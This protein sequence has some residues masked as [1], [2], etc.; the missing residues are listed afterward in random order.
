MSIENFYFHCGTEWSDPY[1]DS[2][3]NDRCPVC[4]A[5][6]EPYKSKGFSDPEF[7]HHP[8]S[9]ELAFDFASAMINATKHLVDKVG[10]IRGLD[11]EL[12]VGHRIN[13]ALLAKSKASHA[14]S[15]GDQSNALQSVMV[16]GEELKA[17]LEILTDDLRGIRGVEIDD[18]APTEMSKADI[19]VNDW[20]NYK[21]IIDERLADERRKAT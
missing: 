16:T 6:I 13:E 17:A 21:A 1:C 3:H 8:L 9:D 19:A 11:V 2:F 20:G 15:D 14:L 18:Y 10:D 5:E 12:Y 4:N 7:I